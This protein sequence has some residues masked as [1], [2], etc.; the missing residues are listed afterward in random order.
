MLRDVR[1]GAGIPLL[2]FLAALGGAGAAVVAQ[3]ATAGGGSTTV[4]TTVVSASAADATPTT[5]PAAATSTGPLPRRAGFDPAWIYRVRGAGVVTIAA[6]VG[7]ST[8]TGSGFVADAA[9][10]IVTNAHV[11]TSSPDVQQRGGKPDE[12]RPLPSIYVKFQDGNSLP[13]RVVGFD[14]FDDVGVLAVDPSLARLVPLQFGSTR[15]LA[16]GDP[17]AVMG[18]PF[19]ADLA[20]SL[21][22]GVVSALG[23][24]IQPPV[25]SFATPGAIQTDAAINHGNSGGPMF[26]AAGRVVGVAAQI[27]STG[28]GGEGVGFAIPAEAAQRSLRQLLQHGS[29]RYAW[30]GV[31]TR[32]VTTELAR[33]FRLP[34]TSGLLVDA[35]T[36][37]GPAARG[38]LRAGAR[39]VVFQ[40]GGVIHP[41]GDIIV[42]VNG[43]R[44][45]TQSD[46]SV[47]IVRADPGAR[48]RFDVY[49][50]TQRRTVV[51]TLGERPATV[52]Q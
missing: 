49:R 32:P 43:Q 17:V 12:V 10:H 33:T 28:G 52:A 35:L 39:G 22:V 50:G 44:V 14:L 2:A 18:S 7:Q 48:M 19:S 31:S 4:V 8:I 11:I 38:G 30:L 41:D 20:Q 24:S 21:S 36:A 34:V 5:S 13:A 1:A 26:D 25:V 23:R 47:L 29:V 6:S 51:I 45:R 3:H 42:A 16:V 9:G 37:G 15:S 40:D 46:L 27:E